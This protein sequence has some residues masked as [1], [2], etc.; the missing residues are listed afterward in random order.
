MERYILKVPKPFAV[1]YDFYEELVGN[2]ALTTYDLPMLILHG[3]ADDYIRI[4]DIRAFRS[5]N[6]QAKL[7]I[8]PGTS[9]RFLEDGA[10]DMVLDL[11]SDWFSY[12]QVLVTDWE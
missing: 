12:Q 7:V 6:D 8:I 3:E 1:N 2:V 9:H 10:W 5:L 11:T 4:S